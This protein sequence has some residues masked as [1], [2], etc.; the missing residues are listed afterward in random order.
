MVGKSPSYLVLGSGGEV[1]ARTWTM[2]GKTK[3][4]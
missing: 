2:G 3:R 4:V 1:R